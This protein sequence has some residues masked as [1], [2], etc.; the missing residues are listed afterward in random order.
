M[1][2]LFVCTGNICR[3]PTAER[4]AV[5]SSARLHIPGFR[6]SSAGTR[7]VIGHAIHDDAAPV[8][9][10]LGGDSAAFVARQ[11]NPRIASSADLILTMTK[12]HRD[13]VLELAPQKLNR[14][15]SLSEAASLIADF[16]AQTIADLAAV[17][18]RLRQREVT[19]VLDP[20]GQ[21]AEVFSA[22][23]SQIADLL[24]PILALCQAES[25]KRNSDN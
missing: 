16:G 25:A 18:P 8:L 24:G 13:S 9:E 11:L 20:I 5:A 4:L 7:A 15:F 1:H 3:S 2:V 17:R 22:V 6:A 10:T 14:T 12:A 19:D 23:G 21:G